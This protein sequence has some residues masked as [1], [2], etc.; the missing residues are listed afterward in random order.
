MW[1]RSFSTRRAH[2]FKIMDAVRDVACNL[3]H[4]AIERSMQRFGVFSILKSDRLQA[5]A[6]ILLE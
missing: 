5:L 3:H 1:P 2:R 6:I 4:A